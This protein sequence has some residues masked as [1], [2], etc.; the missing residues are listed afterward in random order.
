MPTFGHIL[1]PVDLSSGSTAALSGAR[2]I[3]RAARVRLT[4]LHVHPN[5]EP[6]ALGESLSSPT[7][8]VLDDVARGRLLSELAA[9]GQPIRS[10]VAELELAVREGE[11]G[12]EIG[13]Y[14]EE[15]GIDLIVM[16]SHGRTG[17]DRLVIGSVAEA[18]SRKATC[19]VLVIRDTAGRPAERAFSRILCAVDL[20]VPSH[21]TLATAADLA[22]AMDA[23]LTVAHVVE[24]WHWDD[25]WPIARGD[26]AETRRLLAESARQRVGD[27]LGRSE[28]VARVDIRVVFGRVYPEILGAIAECSADLVV[29]GTHAGGMR[30]LLFGSTAQQLLR[31]AP[32]PVL[33]ARP[34]PESTPRIES[35]EAVTAKV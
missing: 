6:Q 7:S 26:E 17:I 24:T 25:P 2:A 15:H 14:A 18:V 19:S 3:A 27:L 29:V 31:E 35:A 16:D 5:V 9:L 12:R 10:D 34:G 30:R 33:I 20:A 21:A 13:S 22:R 32:C 11:P 23:Q 28:D 8:L 4:L 1:V